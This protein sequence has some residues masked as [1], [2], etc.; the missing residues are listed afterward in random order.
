M[1]RKVLYDSFPFSPVAGKKTY[2]RP[3]GRVCPK[4]SALNKATGRCNK[5]T[6]SARGRGNRLG[7]SK[8]SIYGVYHLGP[9]EPPRAR[10]PRGIPATG[11]SVA[12]VPHTMGVPRVGKKCSKG[13][14]FNKKTELCHTYTRRTGLEKKT[15][16]PAQLAALARGRAVRAANLAAAGGPKPRGRPA[17]GYNLPC[18]K[19]TI[20]NPITKRCVK[21]CPPGTLRDLSTQ[22]CRK[23]TVF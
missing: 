13:T 11:K 4:G 6:L 8:E 15:A 5:I 7:R 14:R 21:K 2:S 20:R 23:M 10:R 1:S 22:R 18:K 19:G 17:R 3:T 16:T 12:S 9:M